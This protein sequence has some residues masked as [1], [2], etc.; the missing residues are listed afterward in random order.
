M[1]QH[2]VLFTNVKQ[3]K[4]NIADESHLL[5]ILTKAHIECLSSVELNQTAVKTMWQTLNKTLGTEYAKSL[6]YQ[7]FHIL[8]LVTHVWLYVQGYLN[9]DFSLANDHADATAKTI[10]KLSHSDIHEIRTQFL[11]SFYLGNKSSPI[12][13]NRYSIWNWLKNNFR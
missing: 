13:S 7:D 1:Q 6:E 3:N 12:A 9:M 11:A 10:A 5:G 4:P 2:S 8:M